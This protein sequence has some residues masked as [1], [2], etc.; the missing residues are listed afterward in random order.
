MHDPNFVVLAI[1]A[2]KNIGSWM[3]LVKYKIFRRWK[4]AVVVIGERGW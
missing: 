2:A 4:K 3:G 1:L